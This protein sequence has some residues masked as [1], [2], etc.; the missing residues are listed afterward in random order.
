MEEKRHLLRFI[1]K[2]KA[3]DNSAKLKAI[4]FVSGAKPN[5]YIHF[6]VTNNIDD[7]HEFERLLKSNKMPFNVS[8]AKGFEEITAVKGNAAV[9]KMKGIWYGYDLFR[10]KKSQKDFAKYVSLIRQRKHDAADTLAGRIYCY[11]SCCINKFIAEH[12]PKVLP[13]KYTYYE[14]YKRLQDSDRN[15]PFISHTPCGTHCKKSAAL[16]R[17]YASAI[18]KY[19]PKFLSA[20]SKHRKYSVPVIVDTENDDIWRKKNGHNYNLVTKKPLGGKYYEINWLSKG[21]FP[22]GTVLEAGIVQAYDYAVVKIKRRLGH[23]KN[24]HHERKFTKL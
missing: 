22:R 11:P 24:F 13:K 12:D 16:N 6:R 21:S 7:K 19:S 14:Y 17:K 23:L 9:W 5:A 18:K 15:F 10:N 1:E 4:L 3:F 2:S 8:K 20:Y